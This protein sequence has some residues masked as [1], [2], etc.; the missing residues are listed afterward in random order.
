METLQNLLTIAAEATVIVGLAGIV[1]HA[2]YTQ[3]Q[4]FMATY[5]PPVKTYQADARVEEAEVVTSQM[6]KPLEVAPAVNDP[7]IEPAVAVVTNVIELRPVSR[8]FSPQLALPAAKEVKQ[9]KKVTTRKPRTKKTQPLA[10]ELGLTPPSD[11]GK[12][13]TK[14][15]AK[16]H[17]PRKRKTA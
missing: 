13:Q 15:P 3:H 16:T 2:F 12:V 17:T 10:E 9:T 8:H 14:A 1:A 11:W 5:C 6:S 4:H 7:W